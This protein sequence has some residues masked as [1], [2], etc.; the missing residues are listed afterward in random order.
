MN[1]L[2]LQTII[3]YIQT[4][5]G[6]QFHD[7][8]I[9][10]LRK[11]TINDI[12]RRKNP[13]LFKAK[14]TETA[15]D[16]VRAVLDATV[17]SGEETVFGNF[18]EKIAIEVCQQVRSGR[19]SGV[20]GLDLEFEVA[21]NKYLISIKSGPN[22][23]NSSQIEA[24]VKKFKDAKRTLAT[25]GGAANMNIICIEAC[26]YG[27]DNNPE[28]GTHQKLCGQRFWELISGGNSSLYRDIIDPLGHKAKEKNEELELLYVAKLNTFTA[29]FVNGFCNDGLIDWDK[30][31]TYNSGKK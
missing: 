22:W 8:K 28:K 29:E 18:L 21:N 6:P 13:Y 4:N 17:S 1:P 9:E 2:N 12:L 11:L 31:V 10:K 23:G 5:I 3:S 19:K 20:K 27:V 7:K 26:C 25:S 15:N 24:L 16:F 30:L 14:R